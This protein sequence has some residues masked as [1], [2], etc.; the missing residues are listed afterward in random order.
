MELKTIQTRIH[1]IRDLK[2]LL[3]FDLAELYKV[4][5]R[6]LNQAVKRNR[7]RFPADFMFKL[8]AKE[9]KQMS[10]QI[11]MTSPSKRPKTS[12][13]FA[14]TEQGVAMLSSVLRSPKAVKVNIAIMRTFVFMRQFA[15]SHE[16]L[17]RKLK[18]LEAKYDRKFS[19]INEA[20]HFLTR[21]EMKSV[22]PPRRPIGF[23]Q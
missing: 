12:L 21:K 5:T 22:A 20:I 8:N 4:E 17:S 7:S 14:F 13:P 19:D 15:L 16:E 3:D 6:A 2:V 9:W 1:E 10:S 23:K 18:T 11:V